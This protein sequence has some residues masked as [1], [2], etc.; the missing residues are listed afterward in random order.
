MMLIVSFTC[1]AAAAMDNE[2]AAVAVWDLENL[3]PLNP[4]VTDMG[5]LLSAKVIETIKESGNY[6]VVERERLLL[7]LEE[8]NLGSS[9]VV[10]ESSRLEIG[11]I[12]GAR[13][14]IF[15]SYIVINNILRLD[16]R[17]VE[18]E[19]GSILMAT[20]KTMTG[21]DPIEWLKITQ[22]AAEELLSVKPPYK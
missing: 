13:L 21:L 10:S 8:L 2:G 22:D 9:A 4:A 7:A 6:T 14:M 3:T 1:W 11:R 16:L 15:G 19:T 18:V 20:S 17:M 12:V 5:E